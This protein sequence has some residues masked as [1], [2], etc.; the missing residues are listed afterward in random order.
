MKLQ[1]DRYKTGEFALTRTEYD[2]LMNVITDLQ[3][4][5]LIRLA[6]ATGIRREDLCKIECDHI[7][8]EDKTLFFHESKKSVSRTIDLPDLVIV[9]IKKFYTSLD[10]Q[11]LRKRKLLFDFSGR[12]AYRHFNSWCVVAGIRERPFHSLRATCIKLA[13]ASGW[14]DEQISKLTGD[15]IATIQ[16]HYMTPSSDEMREVTKEKVF[17]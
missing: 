7:S 15:K 6:V 16:E 3:D 12:T 1:S 4:E 14:T 8:L 17:V 5:L 11:E 10:R 2:K 9:C 13:H